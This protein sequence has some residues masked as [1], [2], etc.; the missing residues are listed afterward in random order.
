MKKIFLFIILLILFSQNIK[1]Q[2][3]IVEPYIEYDLAQGIDYHV[4]DLRYYKDING[5]LNPFIGVWKNTTG[6]KTFKLT[7]WKKEM[8]LY[9]RKFYIDE[10]HGDFMVIENEGQPNE[11]ILFDSKYP[12]N[13]PTPFTPMIMLRGKYPQVSGVVYDNSRW[14]IDKSTWKTFLLLFK[15]LPGNTTAQWIT[16]ERSGM[17]D[18]DPYVNP[19]IPKNITLTKQ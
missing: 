16:D 9:L 6:N 18:T 8:V 7:L 15:I 12:T 1:S 13:D 3:T 5:S 19:Y 4:E 2:I 14:H 17:K 11:T 10:I